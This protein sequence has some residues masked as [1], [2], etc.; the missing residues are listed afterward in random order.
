MQCENFERRLHRLLDERLAPED[1]AELRRHAAACNSCD[2][3][4][5]SQAV[6]WRALVSVE[7][8]EPPSSFVDDVMRRL[9]VGPSTVV[10]QTE[11][12]VTTS[13][14]LRVKRRTT[15]MSSV[16]AIAAVFLLAVASAAFLAFR[17]NRGNDARV[18]DQIAVADVASPA[19]PR[20][21][22]LSPAPTMPIERSQET[23]VEA[24]RTPE[25]QY[26]MILAAWRTRLPEL[27][28]TLGLTSSDA[29]TMQGAFAVSQLTD[30]LRTP[31]A[32]SL[33]STLNVLR[34]VILFSEQDSAKPQ[35]RLWRV[36][37]AVS[38]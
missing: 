17:V 11:A 28:D 5:A 13:D 33:A 21:A 7:S 8:P 23:A 30:R 22:A 2:E 12:S 15:P 9:V 16:L 27:G 24:S 4:L 38:T 25:E 35:A 26:A 29:A 3:L 10:T 18:Q 20:A 19:F 36:E 32:A 6:L 1:D 34:S 31:L 14:R 37:D